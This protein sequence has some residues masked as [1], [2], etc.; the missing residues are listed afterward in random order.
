MSEYTIT[1]KDGENGISV[2]LAGPAEENSVAYIVAQVV[3]RFIPEIVKKAAVRAACQC[4]KCK[5]ARE[6]SPPTIH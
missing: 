1:V 6:D 2:N 5:A 4:D 3:M